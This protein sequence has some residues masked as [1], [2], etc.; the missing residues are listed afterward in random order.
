[1]ERK[2][3]TSGELETKARIYDRALAQH[4]KHLAIMLAK[5][6][7]NVNLFENK[8]IHKKFIMENVIEK[9]P[10][11][12]KLDLTTKK[13]ITNIIQDW[14]KELQDELRSPPTS[15][16]YL[17]KQYMPMDWNNSNI[18]L[19]P[20]DS[21]LNSRQFRSFQA[22]RV[23]QKAYVRPDVVES[24]IRRSLLD[25]MLAAKLKR[26]KQKDDEENKERKKKAAVENALTLYDVQ[27]TVKR[28][29]ASESGTNPK[30]MRSTVNITEWD[31][32]KKRVP[33]S[34]LALA[35][36]KKRTNTISLQKRG[37]KTHPVVAYKQ[38]RAG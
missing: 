15:Y 2:L 29:H 9:D 36:N 14:I 16:G 38:H 13:D 37:R 31:K 35:I 1:M 33:G 32:R 4:I 27:P 5:E 26:Q 17:A 10:I 6:L 19:H 11:V 18:K 34:T 23:A 7:Q 8:K 28:R 12:S 30:V 22:N 25:K 21:R 20:K 3:H 24:E